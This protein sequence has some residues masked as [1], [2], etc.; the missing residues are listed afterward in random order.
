VLISHH[1]TV[2]AGI[3]PS[4]SVQ[5]QHSV[6]ARVAAHPDDVDPLHVVRELEL[7]D[8]EAGQTG[9]HE[10]RRGHRDD[11]RQ[12]VGADAC[13]LERLLDG[14]AS[15]AHRRRAELLL[16]LLGRL[17]ADEAGHRI[18]IAEHEVTLLD[19]RRREHLL[20][21]LVLQAERREQLL[22]GEG[23]FGKRRSDTDD[24]G[25]R[26]TV[27]HDGR[28]AFDSCIPACTTHGV[29]P[30]SC[31]IGSRTGPR[32]DRRAALRSRPTRDRSTC[33][34]VRACWR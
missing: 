27:D 9:A 3:L 28:R 23:L 7:A 30:I 6:Q 4:P 32:K 25:E 22:L 24:A 21:D 19:V 15:H 16:H 5:G 17:V 1:E 10:P 18:R 26:E 33:C 13:G 31:R 12:I 34:S 2:L 8:V 20:R 11:A 29:P 14:L